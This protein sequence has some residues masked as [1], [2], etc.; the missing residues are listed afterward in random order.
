MTESEEKLE[1]NL[2]LC[3]GDEAQ[4]ICKAKQP[5]VDIKTE[6]YPRVLDHMELAFKRE[7]NVMHEGG[8]FHGNVWDIFIYITIDENSSGGMPVQLKLRPTRHIPENQRQRR[9]IIL[10]SK[11]RWG[12]SDG[13]R[14]TFETEGE[15]DAEPDRGGTNT[16]KCYNYVATNFTSDHVSVCPA[17]NATYHACKKKSAN[18]EEHATEP[19]EELTI[20]GGEDKLEWRMMTW[21]A[22]KTT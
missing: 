2:Y 1:S 11:S 18:I 15:V 20:G 9:R 14:A 22:T 13:L 17:K 6:R 8:L 5:G 10:L 3:I 21:N 4:E 19:I 12:T 7:R 16:H